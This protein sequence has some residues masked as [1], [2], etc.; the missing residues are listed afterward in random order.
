MFPLPFIN[1]HYHSSV[2]KI[3]SVRNYKTTKQE[4]WRPPTSLRQTTWLET[5]PS[6]M[7]SHKT[8]LLGIQLVKEN[9]GKKSWQSVVTFFPELSHH[10]WPKHASFLSI[11]RKNKLKTN[12]WK[13]KHKSTWEI[14]SS[15]FDMPEFLKINF[16]KMSK[17]W[18]INSFFQIK[19]INPWLCFKESSHKF[20]IHFPE[21]R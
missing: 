21:G 3:T 8:V 1:Q 20:E 11:W 18:N 17:F 2:S 14:L 15:L 13:F 19:K 7:P 10:C 6:Y 5:A 16:K 9:S 12:S 4:E